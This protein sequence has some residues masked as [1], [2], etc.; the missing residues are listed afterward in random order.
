MLTSRYFVPALSILCFN[1]LHMPF[2]TT[3]AQLHMY[4]LVEHLKL[5]RDCC[6]LDVEL[7]KLN[8]GQT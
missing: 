2:G 7:P 1:Q 6:A 5:E 4:Q 3:G 8:Y